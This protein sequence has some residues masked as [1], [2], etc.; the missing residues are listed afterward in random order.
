MVE[1]KEVQ[2]TI[3]PKNTNN[4]ATDEEFLNVLRVVAPGTNF[5]SA[6]DG[7]LKSGKER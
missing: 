4:K 5:R 2:I 3:L 7:A 6:I 1:K